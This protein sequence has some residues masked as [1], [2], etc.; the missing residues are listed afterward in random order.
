M[1]VDMTLDQHT[2]LLA[3]WSNKPKNV[4]AITTLVNGGVSKGNYSAY[5]LASHVGDDSTAVA[6]NRNKLRQD[7]QLPT[8]PLW[9]EQVHSNKVINA[10]V[11]PKTATLTADASYTRKK[12][13]VCSVLT[14]DCLPVFFSNN[15]GTE[16]AVA[17]AGWRGLHA[18]ILSNTLH[19]MSSTA[20]EIQVSLG[21]AIGAGAFEVGIEVFDAFVTKNPANEAAF[22]GSENKRFYCDIYQL[23][24]IELQAAGITKIAGGGSCTYT[25]NQRFYSYRRQSTTGRMASLIWLR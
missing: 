13:V 24:D 10:D 15:S 17:H 21:P 2:Y 1:H 5:N 11:L 6:D 18:G 8:E 12:G 19:A 23:A 14:A 7:L 20:A 4:R 9:L 16:V 3:N 25:E 22:V